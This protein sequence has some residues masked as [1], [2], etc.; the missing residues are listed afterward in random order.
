M[1]VSGARAEGWYSPSR[2]H[3]AF[4]SV[5]GLELLRASVSLLSVKDLPL[6]GGLM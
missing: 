3:Q 5:M 4:G 6:P 2:N 1:W